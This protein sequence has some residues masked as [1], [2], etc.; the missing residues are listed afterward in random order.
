MIAVIAELLGQKAKP[1]SC[2]R[3]EELKTALQSHRIVG[4]QDGD[5]VRR[6]AVGRRHL[7]VAS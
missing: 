6:V 3:R 4:G 7:F 1:D 5:G 2:Q